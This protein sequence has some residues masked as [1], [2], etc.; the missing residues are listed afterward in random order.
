MKK[1]VLAVAL[2]G[3]SGCATLNA[4]VSQIRE[5]QEDALNKKYEGKTL[6][7]VTKALGQPGSR[8]H[9][10]AGEYAFMTVYPMGEEGTT[11]PQYKFGMIKERWK[12]YFFRFNK[13]NGNK[14]MDVK[15]DSCD[16]MSSPSRVDWDY[17]AQNS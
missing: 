3:L 12:C 1:I 11:I 17:M 9:W 7:E 13:E 8:G 6:A 15:F 16:S 14:L 2:L 5:G 4:P 10:G